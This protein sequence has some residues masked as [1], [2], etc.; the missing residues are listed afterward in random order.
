MG[1]TTT[2]SLRRSTITLSCSTSSFLGCWFFARAGDIAT[3]LD[4]LPN[5][6]T[7]VL[8]IFECLVHQITSQRLVKDWLIECYDFISEASSDEIIQR[9]LHL[10]AGVEWSLSP[11]L[12]DQQRLISLVQSILR[13]VKLVQ[14]SFDALELTGKC[15]HWL[16]DQRLWHL[17]AASWN[18]SNFKHHFCLV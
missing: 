8:K 17:R 6:F 10:L 7:L 4:A 15:A 13:G 1:F 16:L 5:W 12:R 9:Y 3:C 11:R 18:L 2:C 14:W